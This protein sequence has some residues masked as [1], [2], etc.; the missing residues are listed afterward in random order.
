MDGRVVGQGVLIVTAVRDEG[1]REIL[2]VE[3]ADTESEATYHELFRSPKARGLGGVSLVVSDDHEG[4]KAAIE[5]HFQ[6]A[7]WQRCQF[8]YAKNLLKLVAASKRKEL[9]AG[10]QEVCSPRPPGGR[11]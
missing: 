4:L 6:G 1:Y 8:H 2:A 10:L 3:V 5:R 9:G 7:S 11:P